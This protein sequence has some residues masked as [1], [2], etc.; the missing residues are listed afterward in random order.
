MCQGHEQQEN[1]EPILEIIFFLEVFHDAV[2]VLKNEIIIY[3]S[4]LLARG[5]TALAL[6]FQ[7]SALSGA[8]RG[9]CFDLSH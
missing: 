8:R 2:F 7:P 1:T 6:I 5:S 4:L 3:R 9:S